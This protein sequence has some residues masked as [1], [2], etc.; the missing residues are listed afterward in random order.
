MERLAKRE[1]SSR[2]R[3]EPTLELRQRRDT[4]A[5]PTETS[6]LPR[7]VRYMPVVM[8]LIREQAPR[9]ANYDYQLI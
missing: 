3:L 4:S 6:L 2:G 7:Y 5:V 9:N 8:Q 1:V